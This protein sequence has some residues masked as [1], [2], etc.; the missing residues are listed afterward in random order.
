MRHFQATML[1]QSG[2]PVKDVS[3]RIGHSDAA[4]TL[5]VYA[6]VLESTDRRSADVIG[7]ILDGSGPPVPKAQS[8]SW[9]RFTRAANSRG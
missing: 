7:D 3:K 5:N 2:I 1:L 6:H 8:R 9:A 4:T